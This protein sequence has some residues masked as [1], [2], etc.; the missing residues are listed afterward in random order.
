[1]S[2]RALV[3]LLVPLLCSFQVWA[4]NI[5]LN[6]THPEQYTVVK[7]D[8]L[9]GIAGK[10]L[11]QPWQWPQIWN[12]NPQIKNPDLIYPGDIIVFSY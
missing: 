1:M 4:D 10:F 8:T 11:H 7:G 12:G 2:F 9:W 6:P 5:K 3:V